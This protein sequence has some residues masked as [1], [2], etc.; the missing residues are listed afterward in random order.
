MKCDC[1]NKL[2]IHNKDGICNE[3]ITENK[4]VKI[5]FVDAG[6]IHECWS[7]NDYLQC[8]DFCKKEKLPY[9]IHE[10]DARA[11]RVANIKRLIRAYKEGEDIELDNLCRDLINIFLIDVLG[12][13]DEDEEDLRSCSKLVESLDV[14]KWES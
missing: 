8:L 4:L 9:K 2:N 5:R 11:S 7:L 1:G 10:F 12:T 14:W 3:C 13:I 6:A